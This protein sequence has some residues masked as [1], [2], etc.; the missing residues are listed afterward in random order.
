MDAGGVFA[1][2][3]PTGVG[4]T[5]T[6]AKLAAR[7]AMRYGSK[8]VGLVTTDGYRIGAHDQLKIYGRILGIPVQLARGGTLASLIESMRDK[9]IV[10]IDTVGVGQR[11][12]RVPELMA[13]LETA[14][15]KKVLLLNAVS[16]GETLDEVI[17]IYRRFRMDGAIV[18]KIDEAARIGGALDGAI[19]H[20]LALAFITN[21]QRVP[22]DLHPAQSAFLVQRALRAAASP[23][24]QLKDEEH[25]ILFAHAARVAREAT[26]QAHAA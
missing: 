21:G 7:Y 17:G 25:G 24:F 3:G 12:P 5:T 20:H 9:K 14:G 18:T 15:A 22:E 10:L 13:E 8:N 23:A 16:Q 2:V 6:T 4:K 19:R 1:L 26:A 11:D